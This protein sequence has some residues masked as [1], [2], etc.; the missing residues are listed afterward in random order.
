MF[1]QPGESLTCS[2]A[3]HTAAKCYCEPSQIS[4]TP[5]TCKPRS[6]D[7]N[8]SMLRVIAKKSIWI[9]FISHCVNVNFCFFEAFVFHQS[10]NFSRL[11]PWRS[12][13]TIT[14]WLAVCYFSLSTLVLN[15]AHFLGK[16]TSTYF[17]PQEITSYIST[18]VQN[19]LGQLLIW[20]VRDPFERCCR[21]RSWRASP[22]D[23]KKRELLVCL[24]CS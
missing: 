1:L 18:V 15:V 12:P 10:K 11:V 5:L 17:H 6:T 2:T 19:I 13:V 22:S 14:K 3:S 20:S 24:S 8:G 4:H 9:Y 16:W 7:S 21:T 23:D